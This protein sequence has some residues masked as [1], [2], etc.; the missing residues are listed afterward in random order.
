MNKS[1]S[2]KVVASICVINSIAIIGCDSSILL[3]KI[4]EKEKGWF[5]T[6]SAYIYVYN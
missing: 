5:V 3:D 4:K 6:V 2:K 1:I